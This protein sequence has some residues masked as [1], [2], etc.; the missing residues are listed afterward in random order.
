ME[1]HGLECDI[2]PKIVQWETLLADGIMKGRLI[3]SEIIV[4]K[5]KI[6]RS[7]S[8]KKSL[9][10]LEFDRIAWAIKG[11]SND[12]S[13]KNVHCVK[14]EPNKIVATDG[15]ILL[16]ADTETEYPTGCYDVLIATWKLIVL[17]KV[18]AEYPKYGKLLEFTRPPD[19]VEEFDSAYND[20]INLFVYKALQLEAYSIA[21]LQRCY[22]T[23][24]SIKMEWRS[25]RMPLIITAPQHT[26]IIMPLKM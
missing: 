16:I 15:H 13:R 6:V 5:R 7:S 2:I 19:K 26:A 12:E 8:K 14:I 10:D 11:R 20:G 17:E 24:Q 18:D 3:M 25:G 21:L 23:N 4:I 22:I 1:L 9:P